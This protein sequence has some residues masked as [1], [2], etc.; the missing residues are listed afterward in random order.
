MSSGRTLSLDGLDLHYLDPSPDAPGLPLIFIHGLDSSHLAWRHVVEAMRRGRRVI[1]LDLPGFGLSAKPLDGVYTVQAMADMV[2]AFM[3]ALGLERAVLC[4]H[5]IGGAVCDL[6]ARQ[7]PARV[8]ALIL[9]AAY[10][11]ARLGHPDL[12]AKI[13]SNILLF[14]YFDKARIDMGVAARQRAF[15]DTAELRAL[16]TRIADDLLGASPAR[17]A[18]FPDTVPCLMVWGRE[19]LVLPLSVAHQC[20]EDHPGGALRVIDAA[21]HAVEEEAPDATVAAI[22]EF[23]APQNL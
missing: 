7:R 6:L 13:A 4:G 22:T 9:V 19:D 16:R 20:A 15:Y 12:D 14:S 23:L 1:A 21:G 10:R 11:L 18:D 17:V 2:A 8:A 5:S 3:D